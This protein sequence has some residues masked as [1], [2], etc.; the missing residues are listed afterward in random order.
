MICVGSLDTTIKNQDGI[1]SEFS[2]IRNKID[3]N[4]Y[5]VGEGPDYNRLQNL[6]DRLDLR[7]RVFLV[8]NKSQAWIQ[9]NLCNYDL[10][11]QASLSEGLGVAAIEAAASCIPLLLSKIDGHI[12][13]SNNGDLCELFNPLKQGELAEKIVDFYNNPV[14]HFER[15]IRNYKIHERKF[16]LQIYNNKILSLYNSL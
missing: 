10:F 8:G 5:I 4:L 14:R 12:E 15:A 16:N 11:I 1:I 13:I 2:N 7:D 6:I 9:N 3:A